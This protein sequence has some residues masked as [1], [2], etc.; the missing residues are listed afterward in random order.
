MGLSQKEDTSS[1]F[2]CAFSKSTL[3]F[4][5]FEKESDPHS[6]CIFELKDSEKCR[7]IKV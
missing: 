1:Q 2:F 5:H 4:E 6:L 3:N 7:E